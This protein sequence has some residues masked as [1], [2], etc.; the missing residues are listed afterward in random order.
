MDAAAAMP[1]IRYNRF[2]PYWAVLQTDVRQTARSWVYRVW[3]F[4]M[5]LAAAGYALF[6]LGAAR[7]AGE[8]QP[9]S[10]QTGD[11]L[12]LLVVG[13]LSLISLLAVSGIGSDRG[14]IAD[15]VLSRGISRYQYFLAKWHSRLVMI[16]GTF[17]AVA[18]LVL[19]TFAIAFHSEVTGGGTNLTLYGGLAGI[20]VIACGLAVVVSWGVS[21]GAMAHST[22]TGV[23]I[24]WL[25]L[26]G[27]LVLLSQLP[28]DYATPERM[29]DE[30]KRVLAGQYRSGQIGEFCIA[31]T[32]L[33]LIGGLVGLIGFNRKDV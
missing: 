24:F 15:S 23:T 33:S 1:T 7:R 4:V 28:S 32:V 16:L 18:T 21:I 30:L 29:L 25:G 2:L 26:F 31:A 13:S 3:L 17:V 27:G 8:F 5:V 19:F 10:V 14:S 22:V 12:R 9:A 20:F 6:K 11:L